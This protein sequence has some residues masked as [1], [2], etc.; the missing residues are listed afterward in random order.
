M[1]NHWF[2]DRNPR[3]T[4]L[5]FFQLVSRAGPVL[6]T[7]EQNGF[8]AY[9]VLIRIVCQRI[10]AAY[11]SARTMMRFTSVRISA[12]LDRKSRGEGEK[13]LLDAYCR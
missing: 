9:L 3:A 10:D 6:Q 1:Y 8:A 7:V 2:V 4:S 12:A 5:L 11:L 13:R